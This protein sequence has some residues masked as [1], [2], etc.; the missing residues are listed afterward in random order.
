[1]NTDFKLNLV[2]ISGEVAVQLYGKSMPILSYTK[3]D[4]KR[5]VKQFLRTDKEIQDQYKSDDKNEYLFKPNI[6]CGPVC[7]IFNKSIGESSAGYAETFQT[8][9]KNELKTFLKDIRNPIYVVMS[10]ILE[11][12]DKTTFL[13]TGEAPYTKYIVRYYPEI[14]LSWIKSK[15]QFPL[16][17]FNLPYFMRSWLYRW[18]CTIK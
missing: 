18:Y 14:K 11:P 9:D 12:Y 5:D 10:Y 7:L 13:H 8:K 16:S 17:K 4:F 6:I 15:L 2:D 1:M 3:Q